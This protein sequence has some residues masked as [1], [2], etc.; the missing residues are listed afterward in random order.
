MKAYYKIIGRYGFALGIAKKKTIWWTNDHKHK[1]RVDY[2]FGLKRSF[3]R[4]ERIYF[5]S[6]HIGRICIKVTKI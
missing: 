6:F 3:H 1:V 5:Y 4:E 2:L